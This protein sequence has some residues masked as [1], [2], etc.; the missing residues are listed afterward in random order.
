MGAG[1]LDCFS[2]FSKMANGHGGSRNGSGRKRGG[3]NTRSR[4]IADRAAALGIT[5]LEVMLDAMRRHHKARR[6][7]KAAAI[8][9]DAAPYIHPKLSATQV[10][11]K[12]DGPPILLKILRG[13]SM[14]EL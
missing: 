13:I 7:D 12:E 10:S 2:R 4:E 8:A 11:G 5:P 9:R 6:Y 1:G 14:S 3:K